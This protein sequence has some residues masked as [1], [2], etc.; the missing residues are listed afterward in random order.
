MTLETDTEAEKMRRVPGIVFADGPTGRRA[1][2]AGTGIEVF[3][4]IGPHRQ[5][6]ESWDALREAFH[7]LTEA[8][9]RAAL[10]YAAAY[11]EEIGARLAR[12]AA[13]TP[14]YIAT[15]YSQRLD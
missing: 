3:E 14:E 10:A 9:L 11:P 15:R 5:M 2:I 4:V 12:Q 8:Q 7:W 1:R 13:I 6:G